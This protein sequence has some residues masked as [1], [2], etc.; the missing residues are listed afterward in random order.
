MSRWPRRQAALP[1]H[2]RGWLELDERVLTFVSTPSD[3][4]VVATTRGLRIVEHAAAAKHPGPPGRILAWEMIVSARWGGG[5]LTVTAAE[6]VSPQLLIRLPPL[7]LALPEPGD[8][9]RVVRQRVDRSVAVSRRRA[10]GPQS[11]VV[12]VGRRVSGRDGLVWYAVFDRSSDAA[13]PDELL[14]AKSMLEDAVRASVGPEQ[15]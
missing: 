10:L 2:V 12:L 1:A 15:A 3:D 6:E 7:T 8:L 13:D 5:A 14:R 9:P 4:L 11:T